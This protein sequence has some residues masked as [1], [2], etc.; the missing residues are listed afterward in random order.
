MSKR[1]GKN[2][3]FKACI[4]VNGTEVDPYRSFLNLEFLIRLSYGIAYENVSLSVTR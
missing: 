1:A 4:S 3:L 2:Y